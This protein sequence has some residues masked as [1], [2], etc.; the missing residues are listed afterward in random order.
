MNCEDVLV[1]KLQAE[2][3]DIKVDIDFRMHHPIVRQRTI[4]TLEI[5]KASLRMVQML[6][7][8]VGFR[9]DDAMSILTELEDTRDDCSSSAVRD[10]D[11]LRRCL[12]EI[13]TRFVPFS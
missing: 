6:P 11:F 12:A 9:L 2:V 3:D 10:R 8:G 4:E 7:R 1:T 13:M 5:L